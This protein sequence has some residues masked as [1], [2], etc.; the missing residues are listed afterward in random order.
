M[1]NSGDK[2]ASDENPVVPPPP[3][4]P[5]SPVAPVTEAPESAEKENPAPARPTGTVSESNTPPRKWGG[6]LS[7]GE[8]SSA[9]GGEGASE[10]HST[11]PAPDEVTLE[12]RKCSVC[13]KVFATVKAL[14]GHMNC[15]P[16]R[17]WK[18]AYPPPV[19]NREEEF[20]N[21]QAAVEAAER[22]NV[23]PDLNQAEPAEPE[24]AEPEP[25]P[26]PEPMFL[27]PDLNLPPPPEEIR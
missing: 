20:G 4:T 24:P 19:F 22:R 11:A 6:M 18:G 26:E 23:I 17:G 5:E 21:I 25:E 7:A 1:T 15:H 3:P 10:G 9:G 8:G 16:D 27:L 13:G 14:F 12:K 2:G